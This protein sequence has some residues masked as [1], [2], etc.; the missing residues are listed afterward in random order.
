M[1]S[2]SAVPL[3]IFISKQPLPIYYHIATLLISV[4]YTLATMQQGYATSF[5]ALWQ[6]TAL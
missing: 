3:S 4:A 5:P 1:H 6:F 2:I